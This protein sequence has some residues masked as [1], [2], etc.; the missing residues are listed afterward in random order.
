MNLGSCLSV[1]HVFMAILISDVAVVERQEKKAQFKSILMMLYPLSDIV[2][3]L[4]I[5]IF[6]SILFDVFSIQLTDPGKLM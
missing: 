2:T 3:H 6:L 4:G 5:L 1:S